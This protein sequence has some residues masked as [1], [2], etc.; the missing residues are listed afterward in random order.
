MFGLRI[1]RLGKNDMHE[2]LRV[3]GMNIADWLT[4]NFNTPLLQGMLAFDATLGT[5]YG[6]RAPNTVLTYLHRRAH[7]SNGLSHPVGGMGA[8]SDTLT[9]MAVQLG[10]DIRTS[11]KAMRVAVENDCAAGVELETGEVVAANAVLSNVDPKQTFLSLLG[12]EHLDTGFLR[13]VRAIPMKGSAAKVNIALDNLP[14]FTGLDPQDLV[15]RL[16]IAPSIDAVERAHNHSKYGEYSEQPVMEITIPSV[17]DHS[18]APT[19]KHVLSAIVQYVP[20]D[21]TNGW[22][23]ARDRFIKTVLNTL[24]AYAPDIQ[25]KIIETQ[26]LTPLDLETQFNTTGGHWHHGEMGLERF[27]MLRPVP[28]LAQYTTPLPGLFLCGAGCHPGGG[29]MGAAGMNA[30]RALMR[31]MG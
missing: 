18:L 1:R 17:H 16:V 26:L 27:M 21:L 15:G 14:Q 5:R 8:L 29:V 6:P 31:E 28:G 24:T 2:L 4:E 11:T 7:L 30:A 20:H 13:R 12:S 9:T 3:V 25:N 23:N 19:G 22:D 10:V